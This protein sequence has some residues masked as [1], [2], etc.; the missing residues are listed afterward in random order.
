MACGAPSVNHMEQIALD[1]GAL[2]SWWDPRLAVHA[3]RLRVDSFLGRMRNGGQVLFDA[4]GTRADALAHASASDTVRGWGAFSLV[5][6]TQ[7]LQERLSLVHPFAADDHFAVREWAWLAVRDLI[8]AG[9]V[10]A[11]RMLT[12]SALSTTDPRLV[13]FAVEATRPRSVWGSHVPL[14]KAEPALAEELLFHAVAVESRYVQLSVG[15]WVNDVAR[16]RPDWVDGITAR[17]EALELGGPVVWRRA[18]RSL[19]VR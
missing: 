17:W 4:Y 12:L 9:P 2:L 5:L 15:N 13:R 1:M 19:P 10:E 6:R 11:V 8:L 3:D 18:R 14:L 16:T 7:E